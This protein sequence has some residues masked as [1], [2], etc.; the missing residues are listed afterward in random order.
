MRSTPEAG[1]AGRAC[2]L[3]DMARVPLEGAPGPHGN[4]RSEGNKQGD[5]A[6]RT[7]ARLV[8]NDLEGPT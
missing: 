7:P 2:G 6:S 3:T 8:S 5:A 4:E 1:A